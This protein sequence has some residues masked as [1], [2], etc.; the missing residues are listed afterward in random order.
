[1][2]PACASSSPQAKPVKVCDVGSPSVSRSLRVS[3]DLVRPSC[4]ACVKYSKSRPNHVCTYGPNAALPGESK[5]RQNSSDGGGGGG[6]GGGGEGAKG[7]LMPAKTRSA[8]RALQGIMGDEEL[9]DEP[10]EQPIEQTKQHRVRPAPPPPL[11]LPTTYPTFPPTVPCALPS[12]PL[13]PLPPSPVALQTPTP[14]S[15]HFTVFAPTPSPELISPPVLS[16]R[17]AS[18][19][20]A[21]RPSFPDEGV[22]F[23]TQ[24]RMD[25]A[26]MSVSPPATQGGAA[27]RSLEGM[28][29]DVLEGLFAFV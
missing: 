28:E 24:L 25:F 21:R 2:A 12:F 5:N 7:L 6:D 3:C 14:H 11:L 26:R 16:P 1:M 18:A 20:H 19:G 23:E 9:V 15:P 17:P 29:D 22:L 13:P 10:E 8:T 27:R 4:G